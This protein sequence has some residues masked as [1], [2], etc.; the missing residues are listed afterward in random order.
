MNTFPKLL[1]I[2]IVAILFSTLCQF[3]ATPAHATA[4]SLVRNT[5]GFF[6]KR[7]SDGKYYP[8][9]LCYS[10]DGSQALVPCREGGTGIAPGFLNTTTTNIP[11]SGAY[12]TAIASTEAASASISVYNPVAT[13]LV[14]G[15]GVA[16]AEVDKLQIAPSGWSGPFKLFLPAGT[17]VSLKSKGADVTS[18]DVQINLL[19]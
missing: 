18:G 14:L 1:S 4:D 5:N 12:A 3:D 19:Q 10:T 6:A 8:A 17:R 9:Q 7:A 11:N 2:A 13:P 15:T 16:L